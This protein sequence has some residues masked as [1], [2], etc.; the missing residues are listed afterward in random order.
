MIT[1]FV[2]NKNQT[3]GGTSGAGTTYR[4]WTLDFTPVFSGVRVAQSA[5]CCVA[6]EDHCLSL[7]PLI[8]AIALRCL[9]FTASDYPSK[10]SH[11]YVSFSWH[12]WMNIYFF[13]SGQG[14]TFST[15]GKFSIH[16]TFWWY[17]TG[18][19]T[20]EDTRFRMPLKYQ[21]LFTKIGKRIHRMMH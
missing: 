20:T 16:F 21:D 19:Y 6:F 12:D 3:T 17:I 4:S 11:K 9:R 1:R 13:V 8:L 10:W 5:D 7:D 2:T 14:V 15:T 18:Q